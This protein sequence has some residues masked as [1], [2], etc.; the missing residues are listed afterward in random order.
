M[1]ALIGDLHTLQLV[2][3]YLFPAHE[4]VELCCERSAGDFTA[5]SLIAANYAPTHSVTGTFLARSYR[6][7][8][9][10][11]INQELNI[12]RVLQ[13]ADTGVTMCCRFIFV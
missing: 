9:F 2:S 6:E 1:L 12:R 7:L 8:A 11:G 3:V 4:L 10:F 5:L 13:F